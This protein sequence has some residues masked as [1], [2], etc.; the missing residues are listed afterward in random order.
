MAED[1][2]TF[3][4]TVTL[5]KEGYII[6]VHNRELDI[7]GTGLCS[8]RDFTAESTNGVHDLDTYVEMV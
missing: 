7:L 3:Y 5:D 6:Q 2:T 1:A 4:E 8:L